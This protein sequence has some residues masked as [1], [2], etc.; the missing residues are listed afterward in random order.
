MNG[1]VTRIRAA[2]TFGLPE[3]RN[4]IQRFGLVFNCLLLLNSTIFLFL[5]YKRVKSF[6]LL[7]LVFGYSWAWG[8]IVERPVAT[9]VT[10]LARL[11]LA[12]SWGIRKFNS[13]DS[14]F[15]ITYLFF[16]EVNF[17]NCVFGSH[18]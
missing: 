14:P 16:E 2:K 11:M 4:L 10:T 15:D 17:V 12:T 6:W 9:A 18:L 1:L 7:F 5:L 3:R 8:T 13:D